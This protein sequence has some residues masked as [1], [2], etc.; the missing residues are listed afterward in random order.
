MTKKAEK[1]V[2]WSEDELNSLLNA[3]GIEKHSPGLTRDA[4]SYSLQADGRTVPIDWDKIPDKY[5]KAFEEMK[6]NLK[7]EKQG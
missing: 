6:D 5:K 3:I 2:D 4:S 7:I 1:D